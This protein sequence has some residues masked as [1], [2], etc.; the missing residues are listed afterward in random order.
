[1]IEAL[2]DLPSHLRERLAMALKSGSLS[3]P[4][5]V[6]SLRS[7]LG[8]R[9]GG[10]DVVAALLELRQLRRFRPRGGTQEEAAAGTGRQARRHGRRDSVLG[11][12][13]ARTL[14]QRHDLLGGGLLTGIVFE[15]AACQFIQGAR[16]RPAQRRSR[17]RSGGARRRTAAG[18]RR[19]SVARTCRNRVQGRRCSGGCQA[20]VLGLKSR[21]GGTLAASRSRPTGRK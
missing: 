9:E 20:E 7:V 6:T 11:L 18:P 1:M 8:T 3:F 17:G 15:R 16:R 5:S 21:Q 13:L 4:C 10:E 12:S 19:D 14:L 2:F